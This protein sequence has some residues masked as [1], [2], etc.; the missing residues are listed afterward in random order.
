MKIQIQSKIIRDLTEALEESYAPVYDELTNL[1]KIETGYILAD[2]MEIDKTELN[3][4]IDSMI[5]VLK[6][7]KAV[8]AFNP[9]KPL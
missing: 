5:S 3:R 7:I 4:Q 1:R 6:E 9:R 2:L 8:K